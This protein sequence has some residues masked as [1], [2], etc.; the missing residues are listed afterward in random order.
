MKITILNGNPQES[1]FDA[2]LKEIQGQLE[3]KGSRV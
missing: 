2:Y 1:S 3:E